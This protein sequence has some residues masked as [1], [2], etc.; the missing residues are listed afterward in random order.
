MASHGSRESTVTS[1]KVPKMTWKK[2]FKRIQDEPASVIISDENCHRENQQ[3]STLRVPLELM[4]N[5]SR[6]DK[7]NV[8]KNYMRINNILCSPS[9]SNHSLSP[10]FCKIRTKPAQNPANPPAQAPIRKRKLEEF[11]GNSSGEVMQNF[12]I[13]KMDSNKIPSRPN[14]KNALM[15]VF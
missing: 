4:E 15:Y 2:R 14:V 6:S 9:K 3:L 7:T 8:S 1:P 13:R 12:K 11:L 10:S 5:H